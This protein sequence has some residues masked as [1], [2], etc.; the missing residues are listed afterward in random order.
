MSEAGAAGAAGL[1]SSTGSTPGFSS[2]NVASKVPRGRKVWASQRAW[3]RTTWAR[4]LE[5]LAHQL[6]HRSA[7]RDQ[8]RRQ[9]RQAR[10]P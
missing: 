7:H 2:T 3:A 9:R 10:S 8:G 1:R 6:V 5:Q 4:V